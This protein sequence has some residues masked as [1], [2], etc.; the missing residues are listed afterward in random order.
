MI[1]TVALSL[2]EQ[3]NYLRHLARLYRFVLL[4]GRPPA[5]LPHAWRQKAA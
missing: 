5:P 3:V 4:A 1:P 2:R